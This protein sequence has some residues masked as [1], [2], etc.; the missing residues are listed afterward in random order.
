MEEMAYTVIL[1]GPKDGKHWR[2]VVASGT[3]GY[4]TLKETGD[5]DD[6]FYV[7]KGPIWFD[8]SEEGQAEANRRNEHELGLSAVHAGLIVFQSIAGAR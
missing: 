8:T 1:D 4:R 5:A 6:P 2:L 7:A 3:G